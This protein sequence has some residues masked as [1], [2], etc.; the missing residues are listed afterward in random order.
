MKRNEIMAI[1]PKTDTFV[2]TIIV[3]DRPVPVTVLRERSDDEKRREPEIVT[4]LFRLYAEM[5]K[6]GVTP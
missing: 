3:K 2:K 4:H 1:V 6:E 5:M